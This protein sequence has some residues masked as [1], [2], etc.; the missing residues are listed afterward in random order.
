MY[1]YYVRGC[2]SLTFKGILTSKGRTENPRVNEN[3]LLSFRTLI[4]QTYRMACVLCNLSQ[5]HSYTMLHHTKND[6]YDHFTCTNI[7]RENINILLRVLYPGESCG[8]FRHS[9]KREL[10]FL[11]QLTLKSTRL[12]YVSTKL[13]GL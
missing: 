7:L 6:F 2:L 1:S 4:R 10:F 12:Y 5:V 11:S 8:S 13:I 9:I 3:E